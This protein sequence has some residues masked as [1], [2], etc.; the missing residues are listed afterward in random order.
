MAR[1]NEILVGRY[2]R[3]IQKLLSMKGDA[4]LFQF[5]SEM[6]AY[7]PLFSGVENRYLEGWDRFGATF[8]QAAVAAVTSGI[9]LRNPS[10]SNVLGVIEKI[11]VHNAAGAVDQPLL[12]IGPA[13]TDL[14]TVTVMPGARMD[15]RCRPNPSL[16]NSRSAA[17]SATN[18][19]ANLLQYAVNANTQNFDLL[20]FEEQEITMLPGD[21]VQV[22][23][24]TVNTQMSVSF[25]WRERFLEE[26]ERT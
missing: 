6:G 12:Q 16:I 3:F 10:G 19:A 20:I 25:F 14:N 18:L 11:F 15:S 21:A 8:S 22:I 2:N 17:V 7:L 5:S 4:S 9:R 26:S 1:F 13:P 24:N 23:S